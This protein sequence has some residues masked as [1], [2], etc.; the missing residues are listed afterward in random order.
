VS[1]ADRG[2]RR[3]E[4]DTGNDFVV[5]SPKQRNASGFSFVYLPVSQ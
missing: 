4:Y 2:A 1:A 5:E 3:P